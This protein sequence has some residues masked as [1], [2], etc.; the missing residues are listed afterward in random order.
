MTGICHKDVLLCNTCYIIL[1]T[2]KSQ[3]AECPLWSFTDIAIFLIT[4]IRYT[5]DIVHS[6]IFHVTYKADSDQG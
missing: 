2:C 1:I 4:Y 6:V 3:S 5:M